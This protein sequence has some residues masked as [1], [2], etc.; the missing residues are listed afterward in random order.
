MAIPK[1]EVVTLS[2]TQSGNLKAFVDIKVGPLVIKKCRLVKQDE[3]SPFCSAPQ[4]VW[5]KD[6]QKKYTPLVIFPDD[7]KEAINE[8]AW[9]AYNA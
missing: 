8:A 4:E 5:E 9:A 3:K 2:K 7:W 6:G 1:I